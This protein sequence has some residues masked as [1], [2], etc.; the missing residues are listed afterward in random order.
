[1]RT[2]CGFVAAFGVLAFVLVGCGGS[3]E[4]GSPVSSGDSAST[5]SNLDRFVF[6]ATPGKPVVYWI[7]TDW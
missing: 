6:G 5:G 1:M 2:F 4:P 3:N 7:H